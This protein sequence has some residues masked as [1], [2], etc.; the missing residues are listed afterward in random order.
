METKPLTKPEKAWLNKIEKLLMNPPTNRIGFYTIGDCDLLTYDR[1]RDSEVHEAMDRNE[2]SDF[3]PCV[4]S[5][6]AGFESINSACA[7]H[8]TAG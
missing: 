7:I 5:I 1:S 2:R 8:S 3:G 6:D 4:E